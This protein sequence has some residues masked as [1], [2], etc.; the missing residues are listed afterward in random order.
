[1]NAIEIIINQYVQ[2]FGSEKDNSIHNLYQGSYVKLFSNKK[3]DFE[4]SVEFGGSEIYIFAVLYFILD[5]VCQCIIQDGYNLTKENILKYLKRHKN[6]I[7][8][9]QETPLTRETI[10]N[11]IKMLQE[12]LDKSTE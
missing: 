10:E 2:T 8:K 7:E 9:S 6:K 12:E 1:M 3:S 4:E 11:I 5:T